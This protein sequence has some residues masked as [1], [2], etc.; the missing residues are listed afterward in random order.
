MTTTTQTESAG[1]P[2]ESVAR[3]LV[4]ALTAAAD[5]IEGTESHP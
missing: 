4:A 5:A 3:D 2:A 1:R